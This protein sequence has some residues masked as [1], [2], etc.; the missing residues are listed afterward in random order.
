MMKP[1]LFF[2]TISLLL[3]GSCTNLAVRKPEGFAVVKTRDQYKAVSPEGM[4]YRVRIMDNYP[5]QDLEFWSQALKNQLLKEGYT[6][7]VD[8]ERFETMAAPGIL[9][10]WAVPYGHESYL[11]LTA[12]I[13]TEKEI[14]IAEAAAEHTVYRRYRQA[15]RESL[16]SIAI[17]PGLSF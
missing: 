15:L 1:I 10:E 2:V 14:A 12:I 16:Q 7:T 6:I 17:K 5:V 13:V 9:F 4:L 11:Y 3:L 8:G